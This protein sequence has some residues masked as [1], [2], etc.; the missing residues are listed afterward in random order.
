MCPAFKRQAAA[1]RIVCRGIV[2]LQDCSCDYVPDWVWLRDRHDL[3][4]LV[5]LKEA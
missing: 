2:R 5:P 1:I 3:W 4:V